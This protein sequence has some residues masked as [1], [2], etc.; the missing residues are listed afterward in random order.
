MRALLLIVAAAAAFIAPPA[1]ANSDE[2]ARALT[3]YDA[4]AREADPVAA[5]REGDADALRLWPDVTPVGV[6]AR[7]K[8]YAR[9]RRQVLRVRPQQLSA[10]EKI[11]HALLT[12]RLAMLIE[13]EPFGEERI[14]FISGDGFYTVA[15][16]AA[17]ANTITNEAQAEAW[18]ARLSALPAYLAA[19]VDNMRRGLTA[20]FTQPRLTTTNAIA[21]VR[22]QLQQPVDRSSLLLPLTKLPPSISEQ[23]Q[24]ELRAQAAKIVQD[25]VKPAQRAV[26]Q[27]FEA[28][29]LPRTR[30]SFGISA[31]P[32]GADYYAHL[33]R[34]HTTTSSSAAEIHRLGLQEVSR[35]RRNMAE[36]MQEVGFKGSLPEFLSELRRNPR[37]Y[38][39]SVEAYTASAA[40]IAKRIDA[41]VPHF[42]GRLP[43]LPFGLKRVP[44]EVANTSSGYWQGDPKAGLPGNVMIHGEK[45]LKFPLFQLPAW[46]LHEGVPGHH[47]Q[48]ALAQEQEGVSSFRRKEDITAFV[49]GWALYAEHLGE[50]MGIYRTPYER[51]G[52]LSYEA[53]RA[54]RLVIDTG[55]HSEGW[56][57]QRAVEYLKSNT[58]LS[59]LEVDNE[60]DRYIGWPG[61]ALAYKIG[62]LRIRAAR[63]RAEAALGSR[64]DV[65]A[66]HDAVLSNGPV[67]LSMLEANLADWTREQQA[68][69][70]GRP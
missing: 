24:R 9:L 36:V 54:A 15:D 41:E 1:V 37:F 65:R 53:W 62:E 47:T 16:Y 64:F 22:A 31:V 45:V 12:N 18:I 43:R 38:A 23:R 30:S 42:I 44:P 17:F 51:F 28:E 5:G 49:E 57:R 14:P 52:R 68:A 11:D 4:L 21:S 66:F 29:Y 27:F 48:I 55:L 3:D 61:Q 20:G 13:A 39:T 32:G 8:A 56:P 67:T 6:S 50:E 2:L 40:E 34:R 58:A 46:V 63:A 70:D 10:S 19:N 60:I 33:I 69:V 7:A 26:L 25:E 35:V 59:Q